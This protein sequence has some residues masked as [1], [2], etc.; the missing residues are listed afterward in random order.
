MDFSWTSEQEELHQNAIEFG[1]SLGKRARERDRDSLFCREDWLRCAEFGIQ[2]LFVPQAY[3][4]VGLDLMTTIYVLEGLGYGCP[5]NGLTFS[6][7][8]QMWSVEEP[9]L[10][11]GSE[12]QKTR[13]LGA[14]CRGEWIAA[15]GM[16]E[17]DSGSDAFSLKTSARKVEGGYVLNGEKEFISLAPVADFA[18]VFA[19]TNP[20][21]K[22]WGVSAFLVEK[23]RPGY[24]A[25]PHREKL[26][27]RTSPLGG[28][29]LQD[30]F[31]PEENRLAREGSGVAI[32]TTSMEYERAF[33]FASHVGAMARQL[34]TCIGYA[35]ERRQF[36]QSIGKFQSVSNRIAEMRLRLETSRLLLY[37][38]AWQ[39]QTGHPDAVLTA[40][41]AK[42]HISE[43][44][45][46]S[47]LEAIRIHGASGFIAECEIER[48]LRDSIGGVIYSGTSDLQRNFI[49]GIAG[50]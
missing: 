29:A 27:L 7:N 45:V 3:G 11:F 1:R 17:P 2:G 13:F 46:Q 19:Q 49:A 23:D 22:Q 39:K 14:L 9:L 43:A 34:E 31:V 37:K 15:H 20:K 40:S 35:N 18:L 48:D 5:D 41:M 16:T 8:G 44:Y 36:G 24:R 10:N 12:A 38:A 30:C 42:L 26:G 47:S 25:S 6:L 50:V 33:I 21:V 28:I 4:G 32:F